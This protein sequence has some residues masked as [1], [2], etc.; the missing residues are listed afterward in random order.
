MSVDRNG[1]SSKGVNLH[2]YMYIYR[3]RGFNC[4]KKQLSRSYRNNLNSAWKKINAV[5]PP[6]ITNVYSLPRRLSYA[7]AKCK[8]RA[9]NSTCTIQYGPGRSTGKIRGAGGGG[10]EGGRRGEEDRAG[11]ARGGK[12]GT[13]IVAAMRSFVPRNAFSLFFFLFSLS[14]SL[15]L[16]LFFPPS[17]VRVLFNCK[18]ILILYKSMS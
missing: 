7:F 17:T 6:F 18:R 10:G 16:S 14:L 4:R 11:E 9:R 5:S 8:M 12:G 3:Y 2:I 13:I 1:G 15:S